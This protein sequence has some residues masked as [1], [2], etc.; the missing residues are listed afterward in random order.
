MN[1]YVH[2]FCIFFTI[3]VEARDFWGKKEASLTEFSSGS[4]RFVSVTSCLMLHK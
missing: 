3:A 4:I 2:C 1:T